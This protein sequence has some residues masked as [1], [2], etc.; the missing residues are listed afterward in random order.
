M[1][2]NLDNLYK[3]PIQRP[4]YSLLD[5]LSVE[6]HPKHQ[7]ELPHP[8]FTVKSRD[9]RPSNCLAMR[10]YPQKVYVCARV[11]AANTCAEKV[12]AL[13][14]I[15]QTEMD[16]VLPL[17]SKAIQSSEPPWIILTLKD[18]TR[19]RQRALAQGN[20]PMF[21]FL[22]NRINRER[23]TCRAEYYESKVAHLKDCKPS[24]WWSKV[25]KLSGM[26]S[27]S[28]DKGELVKSQQHMSET[29]NGLDLAILS[30]RP[31]CHQ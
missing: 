16:F 31:F 25:K 14:T 6:L 20:L 12:S 21:R 30:T 9:L 3:Q 8:R 7:S 29:C 28:R 15:V 23:K 13:K 10:I 26:S 11:S 27:A 24:L 5:H 2:T 4:P 1:L 17:Q 18:L 22:R 19:R